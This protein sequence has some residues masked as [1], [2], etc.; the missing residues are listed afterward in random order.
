MKS[1]AFVQPNLHTGVFS[2]IFGDNFG[3][4]FCSQ[5]S[6]LGDMEQLHYQKT[7]STPPACTAAD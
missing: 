7:I 6:G 4:N 5:L 3:T 1:G 2:K